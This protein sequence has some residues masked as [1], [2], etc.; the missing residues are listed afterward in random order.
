MATDS[1]PGRMSQRRTLC[2]SL[3][4]TRFAPPKTA[5]DADVIHCPGCGLGHANPARR[6]DN[7][8]GEKDAGGGGDPLDRWLEGAPVA[9]RS[10]SDWDHLRIWLAGRKSWGALAAGLLAAIILLAT[11]ATVQL[12]RLQG[13][14]GGLASQL[15]IAQGECGRLQTMLQQR[16]QEILA[17]KRRAEASATAE[18]AAQS[19]VDTLRAELAEA[20]KGLAFAQQQRIAVEQESTQVLAEEMFRR[21][22]DLLNREPAQSLFLAGEALG[23]FLQRGAAPDPIMHQALRDALAATGGIGLQG[24]TGPLEAVWISPD[25]HYLASASRDGTLR[26]WDLAADNPGENVV[27]L[28]AEQAAL[29][30]LAFGP[31]SRWLL[32][33]TETGAACLWDLHSQPQGSSR[34]ALTGHH[35]RINVAAVSPDGRWGLTA[36]G[37]FGQEDNTARLWDLQA[38]DPAAACTALRGHTRPIQAAAFTPDGRWVITAGEDQTARLWKLASPYPAAEQVILEGHQGWITAVA[39]APDSRSFVTGSHDGT[40]RVWDLTSPA[41]NDATR[42][43]NG[44]QGWVSAVCISPDGRWVATGGFDKIVRLWDLRTVDPP[45]R[46]KALS[47]HEGQIQSLAFSPDGRWLIS[48][49]DDRTARIWDM[50]ADDP[51]RDPIV[52]KGHTGPVSSLAI[53]PNGRWLASGSHGTEAHRD[54]YVRL[55]PLELDELVRTARVAAALRLSETQRRALIVEAAERIAMPMR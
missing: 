16:E 12:A 55:W 28:Q 10:L 26:L 35:A 41:A 13:R 31:D 24:H 33:G 54:Y 23:A 40:A 21:S 53:S 20:Q 22:L 32:A 11:V 2:C 48:G 36:S 50:Q 8:S 38:A 42:V 25:G 47:G 27:V 9:P 37:E 46:P 39:V 15:E 17:W 5:D 49:S 14:L 4:G 30:A 7:R 34:F 51:A 29:T 6:N 1:A 3:C 19:R 43:L 44:H 52:L 45:R 18:S